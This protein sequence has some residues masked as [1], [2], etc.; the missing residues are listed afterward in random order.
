MKR[1]ETKKGISGSVH[2]KQSKRGVEG[3]IIPAIVC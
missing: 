3:H 1:N 2:K